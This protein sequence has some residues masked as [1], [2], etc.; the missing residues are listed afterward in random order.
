MTTQAPPPTVTLTQL[1]GIAE[2]LTPFTLP[3]ASARAGAP[4]VVQLRR[5][6]PMQLARQ[7]V[8]PEALAGIALA[9]LG[10]TDAKQ[11][12]E[13]RGVKD[14]SGDYLDMLAATCA[15]VIAEPAMDR[16]EAAAALS[17]ADQSAVF[18]WAN[19]DAEDLARFRGE[20]AGD[21]APVGDG[22]DVGDAAE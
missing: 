21:V 9:A 1:Q 7:G 2:Q 20:P 14:V 10:L 13:A 22:E 3:D 15:A 8:L 4:V 12:P 11:Q 17:F 16:D 5:I 18:R 19:A 6:H